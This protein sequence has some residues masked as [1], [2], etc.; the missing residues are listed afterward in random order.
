MVFATVLRV[1]EQ[2]AIAVTMMKDVVTLFWKKKF[3]YRL[4]L[5]RQILQ[6]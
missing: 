2:N 1:R 6:K 3:M 4:V 5:I